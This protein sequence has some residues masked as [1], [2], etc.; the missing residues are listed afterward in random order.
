MSNIDDLT[1]NV[2]GGKNT[3]QDPAALTRLSL[4]FEILWNAFNSIQLPGKEV[5]HNGNVI[6][7]NEEIVYN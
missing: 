7:N 1:S 3:V 6:T 5:C 2:I 4:R